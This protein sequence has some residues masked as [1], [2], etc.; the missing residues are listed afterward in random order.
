M[1]ELPISGR[2]APSERG[3]AV[4][5]CVMAL[6]AA[7]SLVLSMLPAAAT[8]IRT[9]AA[10]RVPACVT[11]DRLMAFLA[12]KNERFDPRFK[13]IARHYKQHGERWRVR[14]DYAF[15]QMAIETNFL[16]FHRPDGRP[17]DVRPAQNNFA[18][19]G[20][21]G[22]GV[23][24]D[25]YPDVSTGV[26]AQIQHLVAYSGEL[27]PSP[28][29]PRTKLKQDDIVA[30]SLRV[31]RP[32]RFADLARRWAVDP[33]YGRSIEW[34]ADRY[35]EQFCASRDDASAPRAGSTA[36]M[37]SVSASTAERSSLGGEPA[38]NRKPELARAAPKAAAQPE[39][40]SSPA[41]RTVWSRSK[42]GDVPMLPQAGPSPAPRRVAAVAAGTALRAGTTLTQ[43][44]APAGPAE[45][46]I[47]L[48]PM[49]PIAP[50]ATIAPSAVTPETSRDEAPGDIGLIALAA[51]AS[52]FAAGH[53]VAE[54]QTAHGFC[55]IV[56][57]SYG[58]TRT[59]LIRATTGITVELVVL[60]VIPGFEDSM[61]S[62]FIRTR[63]PGGVVDGA[64]PDRDAA[65]DR[66]KAICPAAS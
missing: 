25:S 49:A 21:T 7:A 45:T 44:V 60:A 47:A 20:T 53:V 36:A 23:P 56:M 64:F 26:L 2:P 66:A 28:V 55:R 33:K 8:E 9:H 13:S 34:M 30:A 10:N 15:Y 24:G 22:G 19:L 58:G 41:V 40:A 6:G 32:I 11:P 61:T 4:R 43:P 27:L 63:L 3:P 38:L 18:G 39:T 16:A 31:G 17:G 54:T 52:P 65:L 37:A 12:S 5:V 42:A 59:V 35:R 46:G 29:G 51:A 57:A 50:T 62:N 1:T 14:W 48:V